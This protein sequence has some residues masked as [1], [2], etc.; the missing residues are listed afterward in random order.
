[1]ASPSRS[2]RGF[3]I[4]DTG[5]AVGCIGVLG[6]LAWVGFGRM[7]QADEHAFCAHKMRSL[8]MGSAAFA[9][10]N[11]DLMAGLTWERNGASSQYPDLNAL[12]AQSEVGAHAAQAI[13]IMR[14]GGRPDI[15]ASVFFADI[16]YWSLALV[17]F[18]GRSL[19]DAFNVCASH[20]LL[21]KWRRHPGAFDAGAFVPRQP[22]PGPASRRWPYV[23]SFRQTG[24]AFDAYQ[25]VFTSVAPG[26]RVS[27][28]TS[29]AS[30][31]I[32]SA[33][34]LG[35]SA[36]SLVS[37]PDQKA[38]VFDS[39]QRHVAGPQLYMAYADST[40]P[41]LFFD[42]SVWV[43]RSGDALPAWHPNNPNS[44][45]PQTHVY[46]PAAWEAPTQSGAPTESV[47]DR[48]QWTR[49]GL[50]GRDFAR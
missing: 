5:V 37:F 39:H 38:H 12:Q 15:P 4:L 30:F 19:A 45:L 43:R 17:E 40:Q 11:N 31:A 6:A 27:F 42:G 2:R 1:M 47:Q 21:N 48:L 3:T 8:G 9:L 24:G 26:R 46:A 33:A 36:M 29:H 7:R 20:D 16:G 49:D 14:R 22:A 23:S 44:G 25:S 13:D 34:D 10:S 18:E 41:V 28:G 32:P 50:L 35:P